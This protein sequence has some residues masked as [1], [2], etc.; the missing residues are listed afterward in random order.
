M[1]YLKIDFVILGATVGRLPVVGGPLTMAAQ[2][3]IRDELK[4]VKMFQPDD[5]KAANKE[6]RFWKDQSPRLKNKVVFVNR[7]ILTRQKFDLT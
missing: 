1:P 5:E 3:L 6:V 4:D 2:Q 7:P